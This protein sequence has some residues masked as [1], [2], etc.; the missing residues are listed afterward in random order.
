MSRANSQNRKVQ[1]EMEENAM[2]KQRENFDNY[3][4]HE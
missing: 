4:I 2:K 1:R 3:F